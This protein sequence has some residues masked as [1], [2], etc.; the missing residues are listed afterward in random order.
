MLCVFDNTLAQIQY[1]SYIN[2]VDTEHME[3]YN[4]NQNA[5]LLGQAMDGQGNIY[6]TGCT[7][8][9]DFPV[10]PGAFH[11][12]YYG[13]TMD[14]FVVKIRPKGMEPRTLSPGHFSEVSAEDRIERDTSDE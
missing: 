1:C 14:G 9:P 10:S 3:G 13:G 11:T 12:G 7:D 8:Y 6:L 5:T 2:G 4:D